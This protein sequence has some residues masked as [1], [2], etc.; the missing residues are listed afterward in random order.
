MDRTSREAWALRA[1][2]LLSAALALPAC[3]TPRTEIIVVVDTDLDVPAQI[4]EIV[5]EATGPD[6]APRSATARSLVASS[7]PATLGLIHESGP[8]GPI[9]VRA[10]GRLAG[11]DVV[12]RVARVFFVSRQTR[13]L[14]LHLVGACMGVA[15]PEGET[16]AE[17]GCRPVEVAEEELGRWTGRPPRLDGGAGDGDADVDVDGDADADRDSDADLDGESDV[18]LDV[19]PDLDRDQENDVEADL[20]A[21]GDR[22]ADPDEAECVPTTETCNGRDDDCDRDVDEGFDLET[23]EANCGSCRHACD[24]RNGTGQCTAGSCVVATCE[25]GFDDCNDTGDD[26]CETALATTPAHCGSCE[27]PCDFQNGT[28]ECSSGL[29]TVLTCDSGFDDCNAVG[30]DGCETDLGTS[31][32][33]CGA[34]DTPCTVANGTGDC[35]G[36]SCEV[37]GCDAG[38]DD[39]LAGG[40]C[41]TD[42]LLTE[43]HCGACDHGC[44]FRNGTGWCTGG[45][46]T[47]ISCDAGFDDCNDSGD[48]GCEADL[49]S[50][51]A[52]C[53]GCGLACNPSRVCCPGGCQRPPCP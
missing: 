44:D 34:C 1:A 36:G 12:E 5:I 45:V 24:F 46:C 8:L 27:T 51:E 23:D 16:C 48:D 11:A 35:R 28:G 2:T 22:D 17:S 13:V 21:D 26:G 29:C 10:A 31:M 25:A 19:D 7:L 38:F 9:E 43:E 37:S 33:D 4:D 49:A 6:G 53:G 14:E 50:D 52:N 15:C 41:E 32:T 39:C 20:D 47:V 3:T 18:E 42:I 30:D 40:G